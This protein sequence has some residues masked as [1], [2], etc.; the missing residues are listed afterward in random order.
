MPFR[1]PGIRLFTQT[2]RGDYRLCL[3]EDERHTRFPF[4]KTRCV[5]L[6]PARLTEFFVLRLKIFIFFLSRASI[7]ENQ[8][9]CLLSESMSGLQ[10]QGWNPSP[11]GTNLTASGGGG[12]GRT[13][14]RRSS[15][16]VLFRRGTT[17]DFSSLHLS[18]AI[19]PPF[20]FLAGLLS[21]V[22]ILA[23]SPPAAQSR[24]HRCL[25]SRLT[26]THTHSASVRA[27]NIICGT[28][29]SIISAGSGTTLM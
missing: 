10:K 11:C 12:L 28:A 18:S 23:A 3:R 25:F 7:Y 8:P 27:R 26:H 16:G 1:S 9:P 14:A 22:N 29:G 17:E 19:S 13:T 6:T 15:S 5:Q 4:A 24:Q 21:S 2:P 20:D